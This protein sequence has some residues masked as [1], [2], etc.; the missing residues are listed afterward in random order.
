MRHHGWPS[1]SPSM[2]PAPHHEHKTKAKADCHATQST[3]TSAGQARAQAQ[4]QVR[5]AGGAA[6]LRK[7]PESRTMVARTYTMVA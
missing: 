6:S 3:S 1:G 2:L 7:S 4:A 5:L